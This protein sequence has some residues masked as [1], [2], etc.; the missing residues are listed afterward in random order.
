MI[1]TFPKEWLGDEIPV[2]HRRL[3]HAVLEAW[4]DRHG[5]YSGVTIVPAVEL[6]PDDPDDDGNAREHYAGAFWLTVD[7][8]EQH[9][10]EIVPFAHLSPDYG[11][12]LERRVFAAF[13]HDRL[14]RIKTLE[15]LPVACNALLWWNWNEKIAHWRRSLDRRADLTARAEQQREAVPA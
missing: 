15:A 14:A 13:E 5:Y 10:R 11:T 3:A 9:V 12:R 4:P 1:R 8:G 6:D 7:R 2:E